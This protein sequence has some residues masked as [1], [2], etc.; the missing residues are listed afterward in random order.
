MTPTPRGG[1]PK[2]QVARASQGMTLVELLVVISIIGILVALLFPAV[3]AARAA[4]RQT[5]CANNLRQ[6]GIGLHSN[7]SRVGAFC[8]GAFD[9]KHEGAITEV[10]WVADLVDQGSPVGQMLCPANVSQVSETVNQLLTLTE[11]SFGECVDPKGSEPTKK[12]DGTPVINP[13]REILEGALAA[14]GAE[15]VAVIQGKVID[16]FYNTNYVSSWLMV[17]GGPRIGSGGNLSSSDP[18]CPP[19]LKSRSSTFGPLKLSQLDASKVP[20][21]LIPLLA[22]GGVAGQLTAMIGGLQPGVETAGSVTGGP[23]QTS[24]LKPPSFPDD[25]PRGGPDGWWAGWSKTR[26]DYRGFAVAH[27]GQCNVLMADGGV[28]PLDD[29]NDDGLL[30]NGFPIADGGYESDAI[31]I[32]EDVVFSKPALRGY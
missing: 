1:K 31:E 11:S 27:R 21:N 13:C 28:R 6:F 7:A 30:N 26:Q 17:R 16:K 5:A 19:S 14:G 32:D 9:W 15:R 24:D 3:N 22:D 4:S 18:S 10:G 2:V 23:V 12:P 20:S 8:T 25:T 29:E